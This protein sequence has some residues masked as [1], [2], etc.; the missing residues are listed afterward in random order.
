MFSACP[1]ITCTLDTFF[2]FFHCVFSY[3]PLS[4]RPL[5]M[6]SYIGAIYLTFPTVCFQLSHRIACFRGCI[7]HSHTDCICLDFLPLCVFI[8]VLKWPARE[9]AYSHWLH[10]F[11]FSTLCIF[12]CLIRWLACGDAKSHW[13][14]LFNFS[15]LCVFKCLL[16]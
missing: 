14:H 12:K 6:Q 9:D 8:R 3:V 15:P 2:Y 1:Q 4:C 11:S 10:L 7:L 16:K 5:R 13:L